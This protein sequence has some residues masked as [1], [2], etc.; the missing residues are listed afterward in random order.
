MCIITFS[1]GSA[2]RNK[3]LNTLRKKFKS[4]E[5]AERFYF[6]VKMIASESMTEAVEISITPSLLPCKNVC[7][8]D[9]QLQL[10]SKLYKSYCSTYSNTA[11]PYDFLKLA[12]S[13]MEH[14]QSCGWSNVLYKL[15]KAVGTM[16]CDQSDSLLPAKRMPMGLL[17]H[18]VNFFCSPSSQGVSFSIHSY[19]ANI[20]MLYY[21]YEDTKH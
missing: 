8:S 15:A 11:P 13:A 7:E 21:N 6:P 4:P 10:V 9:E 1:V 16:R 5:E 14:L 2:C 17:E 12:L 3:I 20:L 18:C 19:V